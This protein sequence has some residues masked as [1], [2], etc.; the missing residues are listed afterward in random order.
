MD[1]EWECELEEVEDGD[2]KEEDKEK[3]HGF[4]ELHEGEIY[5]MVRGLAVANGI[6]EVVGWWADV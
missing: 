4:L 6:A 3:E 2:V 1:C 5:E